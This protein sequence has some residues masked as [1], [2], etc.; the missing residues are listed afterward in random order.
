VQAIA[1]RIEIEPDPGEAEL[2]QAALD[3]IPMGIATLDAT[4]NV[5]TSNACFFDMISR[6]GFMQAAYA[7]QTR[8]QLAAHNL[9]QIAPG[10]ESQPEEIGGPSGCKF[11]LTYT[12]DDTGGGTI[13][14][15]DLAEE[16][17][18][19]E[20]APAV[21]EQKEKIEQAKNAFILQVAH[22]F[23]TPLNVIL[24]YVDIM[25][26]NGADVDQDT[27]TTY[28]DFI[29]ESAAALLLNMNEMM[30]IIRLQRNEQAV[31]LEYRQLSGLMA[32][33]MAGVE[34]VLLDEGVQM[35]AAGM[36]E[37]VGHTTACIDVR[38]ARRAMTSLLRTCA[39]LGGDGSTLKLG[40]RHFDATRQMQVS[41]EFTAGRTD[42]GSIIDSIEKGEPVKEISLTGNASGYGIVL[43]AVLLRLCKAQV[44]ATASDD[45]N[46]CIEIDFQI[47]ATD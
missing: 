44:R 3:Q 7:G 17:V 22:H 24:G 13:L 34:Q 31:E 2:L 8:I 38:M 14:I 36:L 16:Q 27:R 46:V 29:R 47:S 10:L 32:G 15:R 25:T 30:D 23:R 39:V 11:T 19:T 4:G 21:L 5:L 42:A 26:S 6:A 28:L 33:A 9:L 45:R 37:V 1:P 18:S 35:D 40:A 41:L 43:A 20:T 12:D